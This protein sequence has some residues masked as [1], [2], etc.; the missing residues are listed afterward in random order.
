M[1]Y[2][3]FSLENHF[4]SLDISCGEYLH[5]TSYEKMEP[6]LTTLVADL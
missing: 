6:N 5:P 2:W 3:L 4:I 1:G